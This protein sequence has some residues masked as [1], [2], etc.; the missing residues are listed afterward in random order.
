M[1]L[2]LK[3]LGFVRNLKK[4]FKHERG[5]VSMMFGLAAVPLFI[6]GGSAIDYERAINAKTML[7]ASLD[8]GA[9]YAASLTAT[10][11]PT[12]TNSSRPY[13][14]VN[15]NNGGDAALTTYSAH[16]DATSTSV[17]VTGQAALKTWFMSIVG[18]TDLTVTAFSTAKKATAKLEVALVLDNTGSMAQSGKIQAEISATN[19]L[20]TQLHSIVI[21]S[22]D[23]FVS[24]IP[25]DYGVNVGT[26]NAAASWLTWNAYTGSKKS[27]WLGC[28][29]DRGDASGPNVGNYDANI[30]APIAGN[31]PTQFPAI[32]TTSCPQQA[33]GLSNNWTGMATV[34]NAMVPGANTNQAIGLAHGWMSLTGG[35]PYTLPA[36]NPNFPYQ[37]A[38]VLLTD[39]LNTADRWYSCPNN[40][41]CPTIDAR[42]AMTC[43]NMKASGVIVYTVQVNTGTDPVSPILQTCA[44]D[45]GKFYYLTSSTQIN[46]AFTAIGQSLR[47][48]YLSN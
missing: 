15:Y 4:L 43:A 13:V 47:K 14:T 11:D 30:S 19:S 8:S 46:T 32:S 41:P 21:N 38:V 25:F 16:Y 48:L 29:N 2:S 44:T 39:G 31:T 27:S 9:L 33:M 10:D 28:V 22:D 17:T 37:K 24:I 18:Q 23:V 26:S 3:K 36:L 45:P 20:L 40:G 7:Q 35:G 6:A 1:G 34:V 12:L 5:N 42:E